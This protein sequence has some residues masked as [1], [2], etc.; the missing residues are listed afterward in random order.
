M[1]CPLCQQEH[2]YILTARDYLQLSGPRYWCV[3]CHGATY[4]L[5]L[6]SEVIAAAVAR[7]TEISAEY[8][9]SQRWLTDKTYECACPCGSAQ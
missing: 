6:S 9:F 5:R 1:R 8:N 4:I 2:G 3:D 7:A